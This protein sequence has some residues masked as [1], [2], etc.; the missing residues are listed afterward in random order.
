MVARLSDRFVISLHELAVW[1]REPTRPYDIGVEVAAAVSA[2]QGLGECRLFGFPAGA[3][4][5]LATAMTVADRARSVVVL[6][7]ATIGDDGWSP[8]EAKWN[9]DMRRVFALRHEQQDQAFDLQMMKPGV[10]E[11]RP[12]R[13]PEPYDPRFKNLEDMLD[14]VGF[15]SADLGG[16]TCPLLVISGDQSNPRFQRLGE[17]LVKV[18]PQAQATVLAVLHALTPA[19]GE[20]PA[21]GEPKP[22]PSISFPTSRRTPARSTVSES[23]G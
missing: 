7:P 5:A 23:D 3:T 12:P 9:S 17:H 4:A 15:G 14:A 6:E 11:P 21:L 20:A 8:V 1:Q 16:I 19:C 2:V 22:T 13:P 10:P 18:V